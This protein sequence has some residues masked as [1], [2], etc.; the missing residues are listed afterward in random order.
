M[1][2]KCMFLVLVAFTAWAGANWKDV[3]PILR[4]VVMETL[5]W[6]MRSLDD[7]PSCGCEDSGIEYSELKPAKDRQ[8]SD[9]EAGREPEPAESRP[10]ELRRRSGR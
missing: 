4:P 8:F 5:R 7:G 2:R 9:A 10:D 3:S 6:A 1:I